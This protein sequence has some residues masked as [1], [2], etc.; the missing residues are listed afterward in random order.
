[1]RRR[2]RDEIEEAMTENDATDF[3]TLK[4]MLPQAD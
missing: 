4:R 3:K 2:F 1:M